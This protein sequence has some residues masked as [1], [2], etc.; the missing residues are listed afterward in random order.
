MDLPGQPPELLAEDLENLRLINRYLG[1]YRTVINGLARAIDERKM[2]RFT[3]LDAGAGGGDVGAAIVRWA[4]RRGIGAR[5]SSLERDATTVERAVVQTRGASEIAVVRGDALQAPFRPGAF[6]FVLA[7]QLLHHFTD[8]QIIHSLRTWARLARRAIIIAD[9]VR[10]PVAFHGIR[11]L[12]RAFT[13]NQMTRFDAPRSV[14]RA[15]TIAEWRALI[16]NADV[17]RFQVHWMLPFRMLGVISLEG[18]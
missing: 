5:I 14:E 11:F 12:T 6:D 3:L 1:C 7:S 9:L 2:N 16:R 4:R 17:G 15:C 8:E 13:R 10:H 18:R